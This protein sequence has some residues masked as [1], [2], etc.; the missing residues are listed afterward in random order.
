M[1]WLG[2][3]LRLDEDRIVRK[4]IEEHHAR[5]TA[6]TNDNLLMDVPKGLDMDQLTALTFEEKKTTWRDMV[7][8][9]H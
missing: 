7:R 1:C 3:L 2:H 6:G 9:L 8:R 5:W 4:A